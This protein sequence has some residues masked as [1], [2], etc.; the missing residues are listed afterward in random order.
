M[1]KPSYFQIF[2]DNREQFSLL[3]DAQAGQLIKALFAFA[4]DGTLPDFSDDQ[5]LQIMFSFLRATINREFDNYG[6]RC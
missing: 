5:S 6:K 1:K 3:S 4:E 2:I